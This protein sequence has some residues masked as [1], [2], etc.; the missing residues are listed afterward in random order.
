[1][2]ELAEMTMKSIWVCAAGVLA[3]GVAGSAVAADLPARVYTKAPP[4]VAAVFDWTGVYVGVNGTYVETSAN[5]DLG[6]APFVPD[7]SIRGSGF[8]GGAQLGYNLQ[9]GAWVF[10]VEAQGDW[11]DLGKSNGSLLNPGFSDRTR[12]DAFGLFTGRVGY[13][14]NNA[15]FYAKGGAAVVHDK[16][17]L[18]DPT[19]VSFGSVSN[20]RWGAAVGGGIEVAFSENWSVAAEYNHAFLDRRTLD[21]T[22]VGAGTFAVR[23]DL[24]IVSFHLNYRFGGPAI[25]R[26]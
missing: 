9:A 3:C 15:L 6:P 17:D 1:V 18:L 8:F 13:A 16:F 24:D 4:P 25:V 26:F 22:A 10:G 23:Q 7:S 12:I 20:N 19:F 21:F 11:G 5:W 2:A 14:L